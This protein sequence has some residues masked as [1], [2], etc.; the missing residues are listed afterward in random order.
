MKKECLIYCIIVLFFV[1]G[2]AQQQVSEKGFLEG[3]IDIGPIC[4]VER[5]PPEPGCQPNEDIYKAWPVAVFKD[6]KKIAQINARPDGMYKIELYAGSY[7]VKLEKQGFG[8]GSSNLPATAVISPG[9]TT[10]LNIEIDTG[11]R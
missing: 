11:I 9:K 6:N 3:K 4:P 1:N 2:C 5:N 10:N 7:A 8:I